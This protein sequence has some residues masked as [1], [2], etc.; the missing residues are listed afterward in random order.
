MSNTLK[1]FF[2]RI[3]TIE[4]IYKK[5]QSFRKLK[6]YAQ[7]WPN[8]LIFNFHVKFFW[9]NYFFTILLKQKSNLNLKLFFECHMIRYIIF[10]VEKPECVLYLSSA[11]LLMLYSSVFKNQVKIKYWLWKKWNRHS[12]KIKKS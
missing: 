11:F 2:L 7:L 1:I 9:L 3:R 6:F 4:R 5:F 8:I 12:D 10:F